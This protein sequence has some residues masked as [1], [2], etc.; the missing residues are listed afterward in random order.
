M[1]KSEE[2]AR[3]DINEALLL[4]ALG[5]LIWSGCGT[6]TQP[7]TPMTSTCRDLPT[8]EECRAGADAIKDERLWSCVRQQCTRITVN[9]GDMVRAECKRQSTALGTTIL[10][11]TLIP[12]W[13]T[14]FNPT[15]EI[16]WCEESVEHDCRIKALV[17]ELAHSCGWR[18]RQGQGVPVNEGEVACE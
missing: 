16:Y 1:V 8:V 11:Y 2:R 4:A 13:T 3:E 12:N 10:G 9:C 5:L 17:H 15:K 6:P 7:G 14:T 18:H